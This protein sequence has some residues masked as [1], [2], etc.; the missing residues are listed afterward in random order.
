MSITEILIFAK[1]LAAVSGDRTI[2]VTS[3]EKRIAADALKRI[4]DQRFDW[5]QGQRE[6][7]KM[8]VDVVAQFG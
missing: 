3:V 1:I 8:L 2:T 6:Q 7:Y 5:T 4:A